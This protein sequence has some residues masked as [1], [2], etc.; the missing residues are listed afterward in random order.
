[1]FLS[2]LLLSKSLYILIPMIMGLVYCSSACGD[3]EFP[4]TYLPAVVEG[5]C[6]ED[7]ERSCCISGVMFITC[8]AG[9]KPD[10]LID[11]T[12]IETLKTAGKVTSFNNVIVT[13]G[14]PTDITFAA[15]CGK[16]VQVAREELIDIDILSVS[17]DHDDEEYF[18]SFSLLN[19]KIG[20]ALQ[21][22]DDYTILAKDWIDSWKVDAGV[23]GTLPDTQMGVKATMTIPPYLVPFAENE[24]CRWR[25]QF[26]LRY[27]GVLTSALITGMIGQF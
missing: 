17:E 6:P 15:G 26:K 12:N 20:L 25:M 24:P 7:E 8:D 16:V 9:A 2:M 22:E 23:A 14:V 27:K 1:M 18:N 4:A 21:Y 10:D 5:S 3:I 13:R 11:P 19:N